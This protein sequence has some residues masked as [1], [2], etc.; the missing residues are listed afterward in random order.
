M[1]ISKTSDVNALLSGV[2]ENIQEYVD[3]Q[4]SHIESLYRI[5][6]ALSS[7]T[8]LENLLEM[9]LCEA[10]GFSN[11]DGCTL[12]VTSDDERHLCFKV[13]ETRSLRIK[14]GGPGEPIRWADLPL[15]REDGSPNREMVAALCALDGKIINIPD[16]Y[17]AAE[18]NFEGTRQFDART[19]FRSR[20]MLVIPMRN[21]EG[22]VI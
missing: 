21:Y 3:R 7:E 13:V 1:S 2:L 20:S 19:G 8:R 5:G 6:T 14:M 22:D 18:Y 16:V 10:M 11:A 9:I 4:N 15:Y 12:Y 17:E